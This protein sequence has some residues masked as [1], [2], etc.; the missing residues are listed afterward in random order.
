[1]AVANSCMRGS[2]FFECCLDPSDSSKSEQA[3][4]GSF[5]A[6]G[7]VHATSYFGS[8]SPFI[9]RFPPN[10]VTQ[11]SIKARRNCNNI[12]VAQ[13]VAVSVTNVPVPIPTPTILA[14]DTEH[15]V[16]ARGF[17]NY[18]SSFRGRLQCRRNKCVR[19]S[20]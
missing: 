4:F 7:F 15:A 2:P 17:I 3:N 20:S 18:E 12:G 9:L 11:L 6:K 14:A 8:S 19:N 1:M 13:V 10:F 16:T 5:P